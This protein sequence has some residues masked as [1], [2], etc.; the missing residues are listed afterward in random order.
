MDFLSLGM[1]L[2]AGFSNLMNHDIIFGI[3]ILV[4]LFIGTRNIKKLKKTFVALIIGLILFI[5][6]KY[7]FHVP[8]VCTGMPNCPSGFGFPSGHST[9]VSIIALAFVKTELFPFYILFAILVMYSRMFVHA[10]TFYQVVASLPIAVL[11][12][13]TTNVLFNYAS[14]EGIINK[15]EAKNEIGRKI[16][17]IIAAFIFV[18]LLLYL[19][20]H[21]F[22]VLTFGI[23]VVGGLLINLKL[24]TKHVPFLKFLDHIENVLERPGI[25]T[26]AFG[27]TMYVLGILFATVSPINISYIIAIF[28][29]LGVGDGMATIV[30]KKYGKHRILDGKSVEGFLAFFVCTSILVYPLIGW[31]GVLGSLLGAI[32]ELVSIGI[33]DNLVI[34]IALTMFFYL[35]V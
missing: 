32:L 27:T 22:A 28:L 19:G 18:G 17:H 30:G 13:H 4:A 3:T 21:T 10:H 26:P 8:R 2:F 33:D 11:A 34:P 1:N 29:I 16:V 24:I 31:I 9:A 6:L 25:Q 20:R 5:I 15:K 23:L 35:F 7:Y 12:Y 14:K